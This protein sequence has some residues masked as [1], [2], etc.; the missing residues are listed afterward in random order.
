MFINYAGDGQQVD[1]ELKTQVSR[2]IGTHFR[3]RSKPSGRRISGYRP[4][5]HFIS[6]GLVSK[7]RSAAKS[8]DASP[9]IPSILYHDRAGL[10]QNPFLSYPAR[11]SPAVDQAVD[12]CTHFYLWSCLQTHG[13][14][15]QSYAATA[16]HTC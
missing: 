13:Q 7:D 9:S 16:L 14:N 3:N 5:Q 4:F 12:H 1:P 15:L 10:R 11:S 8:R 2:Y 6:T